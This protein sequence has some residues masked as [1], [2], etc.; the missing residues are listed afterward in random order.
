[1]LR[2]KIIETMLYMTRTFSFCSISH[3][4][5]LLILNLMRE[6]FDDD[7]VETMKDF[8]RKELERDM[9]FHFKSGRTCSRTNIGQIVK[10]AFELRTI[11]QKQINDMDSDAEEDPATDQKDWFTFCETKVAAIEKVWNQKLD[12]TEPDPREESSPMP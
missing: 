10:I 12:R 2:K 9:N 3:Q 8:V 5:S 11:T 4:Q 6:A 7:D 1:M